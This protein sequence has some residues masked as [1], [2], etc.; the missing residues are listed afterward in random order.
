M[1]VLFVFRHYVELAL[2]DILAAAGAFAIDLADRKFG[3][4]LAALWRE[5]AKVFGN[6]QIEPTA[7]HAALI[8]EL[9]ELDARADAF[10]YALNALDQKQFERIGS[11]DLDALMA[12]I[13]SISGLFERALDRMEKDEAEMDQMIEEAVARDPY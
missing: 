1:P 5:T 8:T 11:V 2:K 7:A 9:V 6:F 13:D 3:H 10:R 12:A 4:D